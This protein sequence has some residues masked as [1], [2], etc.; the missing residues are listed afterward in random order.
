MPKK[1]CMKRAGLKLKLLKGMHL[2]EDHDHELLVFSLMAK[3]SF[4]A[5]FFIIISKSISCRG[6]EK[7]HK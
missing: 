3:Y 2:F 4:A 5:S 6:S 7:L 1:K